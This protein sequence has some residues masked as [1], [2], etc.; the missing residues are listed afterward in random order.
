VAVLANDR[1]VHE[2]TRV[3]PFPYTEADAKSWIDNHAAYVAS[4]LSY[5]F[6]VVERLS[7]QL[8]GAVEV[9]PDKDEADAYELGYWI[10][11]PFR[12]RGFAT[13]ASRLVLE[14][15]SSY[16]PAGRLGAYVS[17]D[18]IAS[19]HVLAKCGMR[20]VKRNAQGSDQD[21]FSR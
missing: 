20:L 12:G 13:E 11:A 5:S 18:N 8:V 14:W 16:L 19:R 17:V 4:S 1:F 6:A 7:E 10:G 3:T 21:Y 9:R 15:A 2:G